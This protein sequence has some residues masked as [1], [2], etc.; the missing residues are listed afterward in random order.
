[1]TR[2]SEE[3]RLQYCK[4]CGLDF[5]DHD[6]ELCDSKKYPSLFLNGYDYLIKIAKLYEINLT[7]ANNN[8]AD[9]GRHGSIEGDIYLDLCSALHDFISTDLKTDMR[10][11]VIEKL[12]SW[13]KHDEIS[14]AIANVEKLN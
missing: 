10:D 12:S 1:M 13:Y 11:F 2:T 6:K 3:I 8:S 14:E 9:N 7:V 4:K 5:P